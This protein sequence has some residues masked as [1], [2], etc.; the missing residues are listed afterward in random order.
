MTSYERE[1]DDS[2]HGVRQPV[3]NAISYT[4]GKFEQSLG[5]AIKISGVHWKIPS[6]ESS[7]FTVQEFMSAIEAASAN[8]QWLWLDIACI[9]QEDQRVKIDEIGNQAAIFERA[10][11]VYAWLTPWTTEKMEHA[12]YILDTFC[13]VPVDSQHTK[14]FHYRFKPTNKLPTPDQH[15]LLRAIENITSQPFF[16]S[17]WTL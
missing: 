3:Y 16:K 11:T 10:R 13:P 17:V 8:S 1:Q 15:S 5:P 2:Y 6:I 14:V 12:F 4:W 7:H 9:D